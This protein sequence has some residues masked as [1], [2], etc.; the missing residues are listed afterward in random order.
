MNKHF[1][2]SRAFR[3]G[4]VASVVTAVVL[5]AAVLLNM[6]AGRLT[7]RYNLRLDLTAESVLTLTSTTTDYLKTLDKDVSIY[8]LNSEQ[9]FAAEGTYVVQAAE[10]IGQYAAHSNRITV[11]YIDLMQNP[12][13]SSAYP[14]VQVNDIMVSCG[15]KYRLLT[16]ED[17][18]NFQV[19]DYGAYITSSKAEQTMTGAI[20]YVTSDVVIRAGVLGGHS[21]SAASGLTTLLQLNNYEI[22]PV[23]PAS[24]DIPSD[25]DI[26]IISAPR[27]DYTEAELKRL[28]AFLYNNGSYGKTLFYLAA[29]DQPSLPALDAFLAQWGIAVGEGAVFET[30]YS[31]LS[32][33]SRFMTNALYA[34]GEYSL[35]VAR[36]GLPVTMPNARPLEILT[37]GDVAV[38]PLLTFSPTAGIRPFD[39]PGDWQPT[40]EDLTADIP[41]LLLSQNATP[42]GETGSSVLVASTSLAVEE[43]ILATPVLANSG[44]FLSVLG[45]LTDRADN[46]VI[47]SKQVG[48]PMLGISYGQALFLG[49]IFFIG[50]PLLVLIAG[51]VMFFHRRHL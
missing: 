32:G 17:L 15:E 39:A 38:T 48:S 31:M 36:S 42:G 14:E 9:A 21:E 5:V 40:A 19:D 3:Q 51:G 18:F 33:N 34:E 45:L 23:T 25:L 46:L 49:A 20:S 50:L 35:S 2:R 43:Q 1:F 7:A 41:A 30:D 16:P 6:A 24:Q 27:V 10:A 8:I 22:T 29:I 44:Y 28:D 13:F 12:G 47:E 26:A 4:S 37:T 11:A